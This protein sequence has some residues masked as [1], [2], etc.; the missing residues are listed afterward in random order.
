[1]RDYGRTTL[2]VDFRHM[3]E[4]DDVLARAVSEQYYRFLPY[5][6]RALVDL[7]NA[8]IPGYLYLNAHVASTASSGLV[9]RDFSL[10]FYNLSI[11]SGIR[12]LH[13]D[14]I[15][16]LLSISGTVTRTSEVRPELLF[17]T[18]TCIECKTSVPDVEQQFRYTCLLYTSPSPRD[19]G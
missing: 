8:Y 6:R 4:Y 12:S 7:V 16:R 3:L 10:S 14:K 13:T 2:Y 17:G 11:I 5:L 9:T 18:F 19:R 1:M 15:G